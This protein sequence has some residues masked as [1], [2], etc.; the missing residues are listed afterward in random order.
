MYYIHLIYK[1][2]HNNLFCI[3]N[4]KYK[5]I[6]TYNGGLYKECCKCGKVSQ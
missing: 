1:W 3:H 6:K 5:E 4:W 2:I